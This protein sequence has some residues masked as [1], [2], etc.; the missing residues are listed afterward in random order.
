MDILL[1]VLGV[2]L[3]IAGLVGCVLPV[4]PGPPLAWLALLLL[5]FTDRIPKDWNMVW[6]TLAVAVAVQVLDYIVPAMGTKKFGGTKYGVWGAMIGLIVGLITPIPL[7]VIV[8]PF[9]GAF[10]G[11]MM[12][13]NQADKALRAAVGSLV[14]FLFSTGMKIAVVLYFGYIF[15]NN[16][17]VL[18]H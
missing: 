2:I 6:M 18:W 13:Q 15:F 12:H 17:A 9:L 7:G 4:I 10:I 8:G 5:Q 16:I 1:I 3:L 11:E 14:G